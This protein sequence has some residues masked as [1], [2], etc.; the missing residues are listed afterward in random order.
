M[1]CFLVVSS[2][3]IAKDR[4]KI[5]EIGRGI[6]SETLPDMELDQPHPSGRTIAATKKIEAPQ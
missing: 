3:I 6:E 1:V 5:G 4:E 2:E